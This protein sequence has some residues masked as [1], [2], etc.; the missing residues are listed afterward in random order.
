ML[1]TD[2]YCNDTSMKE[3]K[4]GYIDTNDKDYHNYRIIL[5]IINVGN[6]PKVEVSIIGYYD[7]FIRI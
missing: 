6:C 1:F 4:N 3:G 2:H 5:D 7:V